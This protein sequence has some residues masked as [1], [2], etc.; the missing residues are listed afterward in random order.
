MLSSSTSNCIYYYFTLEVD[1]FHKAITKIT[2]ED[3][4]EAEASAHQ[5]SRQ[6][7]SWVVSNMDKAAVF[8]RELNGILQPC[9]V[10][11][12]NKQRREKIW[13]LYHR[14]RTSNVFKQ[15]W[16]SF[17]KTSTS[18]PP[19]ALFYQHLTDICIYVIRLAKNYPHYYIHLSHNSP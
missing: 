13:S 14:I 5:S 7:Q 1:I 6:L 17:L 10:L 3:G 8:V 9:L 16:E 19:N 12:S 11:P 2:M 18:L 15:L 4:F